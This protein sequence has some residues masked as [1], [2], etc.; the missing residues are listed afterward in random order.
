L[1]EETLENIK[2][3]TVQKE[4]FKARRLGERDPMFSVLGVDQVALDVYYETQKKFVKKPSNVLA[5]EDALTSV[6][7]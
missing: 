4:D 3:K 7:P 5:N 1:T 2:K 6:L